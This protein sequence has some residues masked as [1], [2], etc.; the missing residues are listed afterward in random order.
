MNREIRMSISSMTRTGDKKAIYILFT[1][2]DFSAEFSIPDCKLLSSHGF[3]EEDLKQLKEY[4]ENEQDYLFSMAKEI[5]PIRNFLG[6]GKE[7]D[8][9]KSKRIIV[10]EG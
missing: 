8:K 3:S 7:E 9:K 1:D 6:D 5:N 2:G 10:D 4:I